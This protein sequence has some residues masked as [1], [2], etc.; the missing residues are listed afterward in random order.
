MREHPGVVLTI[1]D[2]TELDYTDI[3]EID[4]PAGVEPVE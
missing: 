4:P 1:H 2:T 3:Q